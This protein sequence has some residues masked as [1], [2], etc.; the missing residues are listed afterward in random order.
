MD[1]L[2]KASLAFQHIE[3]PYIFDEACPYVYDNA[4]IGAWATFP[5][6]CGW[7]VRE[8]AADDFDFT[9]QHRNTLGHAASMLQAW[10]YFGMI[11]LVTGLPA[12]TQDYIRL[13]HR[14][15]LV[16]TTQKLPEHLERYTQGLRSVSE[17]GRPGIIAGMDKTLKMWQLCFSSCAGKN[18]PLPAEVVLSMMILFKTLIYAKLSVFPDSGEPAEAW[19]GTTREFMDRRLQDIG[20]CSMDVYRLNQRLSSLAQYYISSLDLRKESRSHEKCSHTQCVALQIDEKTYKARHTS[21]GCTCAMEVV[22]Q[23]ELR[24]S[25]KRDSIPTITFS[26]T[27]GLRMQDLNTQ[28]GKP[29]CPYVAISHLWADG[30]GNPHQNAMPRCQL[31]LLQERVN[32]VYTSTEGGGS[33]QGMESLNVPFWIDTLCVPAQE[34]EEKKPA[35]A[36]M[37]LIYKEATIVLVIDRELESIGSDGTV[38]EI[39]VRIAMSSWWTR[40]WTLQEGA[41]AKELQFQLRGGAVSRQSLLRRDRGSEVDAGTHH[42]NVDQAIIEEALGMISDI[43]GLVKSIDTDQGRYL[44]QSLSWRFAS[45]PADE[46]ICISILL[47]G[48]KE[49]EEIQKMPPSIR[50]KEFIKSQRF[51]PSVLLFVGRDTIGSLEEEGYRWAPKSLIG[52][53]SNM[54]EYILKDPRNLRHRPWVA[55]TRV[56]DTAYADHNGLHVEYPGMTLDVN[57]TVQADPAI[58]RIL[59][60]LNQDDDGW[61][62]ALLAVAPESKISWASLSPLLRPA[63]IVPRPLTMAADDRALKGILVDIYKEQDGELFCHRRCEVRVR[64]HSFRLSVEAAAQF[65]TNRARA[66]NRDISQKWCVG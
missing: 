62:D 26:N 25:V 44:L 22:G 63:L 53:Y 37:A 58:P 60:F 14:G 42:W 9:R 46:T 6:R 20:C 30:L 40:L 23:P 3:V 16:V 33:L 38:L 8:M 59:N 17:K 52:R 54:T 1:H 10:L 47:K 21:K 41:F 50:L 34:C 29:H 2:P 45:Y 61:Y 64:I 11:Q 39:S 19:Y 4:G 36:S 27:S 51:F 28:L 48:G 12:T 7:S 49:V 43:S 55:D 15:Q 57:G 24:A 56:A 18:S 35:I 13:N 65:V 5:E 66:R 31:A 32:A